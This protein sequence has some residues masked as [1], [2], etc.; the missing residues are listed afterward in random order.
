MEKEKVMEWV[1]KLMTKAMHKGTPQHEIDACESKAAELMA[2][3][4]I[5]MTQAMHS[6]ESV[7]PMEG[8][9]R[10]DMEFI[11][12]SKSTDWGYF[13]GFAIA[14]AFD[15]KGISMKYR[16]AFAFM[17]YADDV[18][19]C[20]WFFDYLQIEIYMWAEKFSKGKRKQNAYARGM[21]TTIRER[22]V[23]LYRK[24]E[25]IIPSDCR[26]LIVINKEKV[27]Q[28]AKNEFP[29]THTHK[30]VKLGGNRNAYMTGREDGKNL[31]LTNHNRSKVSE[32]VKIG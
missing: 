25:E 4:K 28:F 17:G 18:D 10:D 8:I 32:Q 20:K 11:G 3:Y 13:L 5:S 29:S 31:D 2:R 26:A 6:E 30:S 12:A 23:S 1:Q 15:C 22:L 19:T 24:V 14:K 27:K 21:V 7:D 16:G 9:E